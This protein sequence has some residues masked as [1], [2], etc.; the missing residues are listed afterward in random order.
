M[1]KLVDISS[2]E[3]VNELNAELEN[4]W[5]I[6]EVYPELKRALIEKKEKQTIVRI[7]GED[8]IK[9]YLNDGWKIKH[10]NSASS[11]DD[12]CCFVWLEK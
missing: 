4:G 1:Q 6:V 7:Y 9:S 10:M 5:E 11:A 12:Y 8:G 3:Q 2:L